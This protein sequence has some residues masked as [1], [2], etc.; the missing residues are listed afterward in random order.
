MNPNRVQLFFFLGVLAITLHFSTLSIKEIFQYASLNSQA[1]AHIKQWEIVPLK[2]KF[3]LKADFSFDAIGKAW[4]GSYTFPEPYHLNEWAALSE[5]KK[6]AKA[7]WI[8][9]YHNPEEAILEK[10]FPTSTLVKTVICY[11]VLLYFVV[12]RRKHK[13]NLT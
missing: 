8:A 2:N 3:A 5:L 4:P 11:F 10:N 13:V 7:P 6:K 12:L 1:P 9:H